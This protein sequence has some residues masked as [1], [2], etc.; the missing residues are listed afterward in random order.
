MDNE[1]V[2]GCK[3]LLARHS[4]ITPVIETVLV[5]GKRLAGKIGFSLVTIR[6]HRHALLKSDG[7]G[8]QLDIENTC[9]I[10]QNSGVEIGNWIFIINCT[11][12]VE[13]ARLAD[14]QVGKLDWCGYSEALARRYHHNLAMKILDVFA[15]K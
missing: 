12:W 4:S 7:G 13:D 3:C 8:G 1:G 10:Q 2:A 5:T 6:F 11:I 9:I 15:I 14:R